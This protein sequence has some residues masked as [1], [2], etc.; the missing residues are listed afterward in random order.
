MWLKMYQWKR[1][2]F[3]L[4]FLLE[5]SYWNTVRSWCL[6]YEKTL[7]HF[8]IQAMYVHRYTVLLSFEILEKKFPIS[9]LMEKDNMY[10][11]T[12]RLW[13][14]MYKNKKKEK[15]R[16]F[17]P[18]KPATHIPS[19]YVRISIQYFSVTNSWRGTMCL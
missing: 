4:S 15:K 5:N 11:N 9:F 1:L 6:V 2:E 13:C 14:L 10:W 7:E 12:V 8:S 18:F 17:F 16:T 19:C 3:P